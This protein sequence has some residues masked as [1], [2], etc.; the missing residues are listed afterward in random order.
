MANIF[1]VKGKDRD[2]LIDTGVGIH[3]LP[4][5]LKFSGL[6]AEL[7]ILWTWFLLIYT[8][9]IWVE[10]T[11]SPWFTSTPWRLTTSGMETSS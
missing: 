4:A 10:L 3:S 5:F 9:T 7:D 8:L 2:L 6:R 11:S 1:F